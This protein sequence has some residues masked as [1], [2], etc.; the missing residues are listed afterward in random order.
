MSTAGADEGRMEIGSEPALFA[1]FRNP[2]GDVL[3][4][5]VGEAI[6]VGGG[7]LELPDLLLTHEGAARLVSAASSSAKWSTIRSRSFES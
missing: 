4:A 7:L 2:D 6:E 5:M 1:G 3:S